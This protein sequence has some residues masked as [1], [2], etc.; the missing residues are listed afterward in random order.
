MPGKGRPF[1][2]GESGNP[3]GRPPAEWSWSGTLRR[4]AEEEQAKGI[5]LK[6][7]MGKSLIKEGL[8]GNIP[9]IKEFGDRIDGK[10][11]QGVDL[12]HSG[13]VIVRIEKSGGFTTEG[14]KDEI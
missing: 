1:K 5:Q 7:L 14:Q 10:A 12:N 4:L 3:N 11:N 6:E 13:E 8:K 9:A 2:K